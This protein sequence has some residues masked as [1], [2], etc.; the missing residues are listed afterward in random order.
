MS[1]LAATDITET[2]QLILST[3][4]QLVDPGNPDAVPGV[5]ALPP[6][7][8]VATGG[9]EYD[10]AMVGVA[11]MSIQLGFPEPTS[12]RIGGAANLTFPFGNTIWTLTAEVAIVRCAEE[13]YDGNQ[14][15]RPEWLANDL[16]ASSGD[17]ALLIE[18]AEF[19]VKALQVPVPHNVRFTSPQG[20]LLATQSSITV[21]IG[22]IP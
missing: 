19:L 10:C 17:A 21:P 13:R 1:A 9:M 20:Q 14:P 2:C 7:Q 8:I 3:M 15:P 6:R 22:W 4:I 12:Q 11:A 18:T 16:I 5:L